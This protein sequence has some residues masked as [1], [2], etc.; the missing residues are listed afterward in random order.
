MANIMGVRV[1]PELDTLNSLVI[2]NRPGGQ[3]DPNVCFNGDN[4]FVIWLDNAFDTVSPAVIV[5]RITPQGVILD[6]GYSVGKGDEKP[7]IASDNCNCLVVWSKEYYGVCA[8]IIDSLAHPCSD[9]VTISKT[10]ATSTWPKVE[11][12]NENYLVV[13]PDFCFAGTDLDVFG[14]L[15]SRDGSLIGDRITIADGPEIQNSANLVF[16]G[17]N[18]LVVWLEGSM[19]HNVF[20][21]FVSSDGQVLGEKFKISDDTMFYRQNVSVASG[22]DNY[23]VVWGEYRNDLDIY[24]NVDISMGVEE[25]EKRNEALIPT[26]LAGPLNV[27]G[28][29]DFQIF[30]ILG[31]SIQVNQMK[32]G[33]YFVKI[34]EQSIK[35]VVKVR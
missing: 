35:K 7:D 8:Q 11:F 21:R 2:C 6:S 23:L 13:W 3:V 31:R 19:S 12:G 4:Y 29:D 22:L 32:A 16:D 27:I 17:S 30:D 18:F 14:Q 28:I 33:V 1:T 15:I 34:N 9:S 24:G 5:T 25:Q 10:L 26:I 20:G